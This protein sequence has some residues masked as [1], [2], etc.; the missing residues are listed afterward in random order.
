M[1]HA[2]LQKWGLENL[3]F[4]PTLEKLYDLGLRV[5]TLEGTVWEKQ[6]A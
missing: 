6:G 5:K 3:V 2:V 1:C 4:G